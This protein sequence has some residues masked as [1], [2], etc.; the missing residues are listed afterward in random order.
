MK[1]KIFSRPTFLITLH[2]IY[3][4]TI[5]R[6]YHYKK[7]EFL[8]SLIKKKKTFLSLVV[9][10][11]LESHLC[12]SPFTPSRA[13]PLCGLHSPTIEQGGASCPLSSLTAVLCS[14]IHRALLHTATVWPSS[15]RRSSHPSQ[16]ITVSVTKRHHDSTCS[17]SSFSGAFLL[18]RNHASPSESK[19]RRETMAFRQKVLLPSSGHWKMVLTLSLWLREEVEFFLFTTSADSRQQ[20]FQSI[21][22]WLNELHTHSDMNVVTFFVHSLRIGTSLCFTLII[23]LSHARHIPNHLLQKA[24]VEAPKQWWKLRQ[25]RL[26]SSTALAS[27]PHHNHRFIKEQGKEKQWCDIAAFPD[28]AWCGGEVVVVRWRCEHHGRRRLKKNVVW[29]PY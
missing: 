3:L 21:G 23:S 5:P 13:P 27:P 26:W 6:V 22:R 20:T 10:V 25:T 28:Q 17:K 29:W 4:I 14:S 7:Y 12:V 9:S 19:W 18:Q 16:S 8:I 1:M 2:L 15:P 11:P 24:T